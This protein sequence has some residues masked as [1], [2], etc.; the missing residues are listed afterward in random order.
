MFG[1]V[2]KN[3]LIIKSNFCAISINDYSSSAEAAPHLRDAFFLSSKIPIIIFPH[4]LLLS[5]N[6]TSSEEKMMTI[7]AS[8]AILALFVSC[9]SQAKKVSEEPAELAQQ[10]TGIRKIWVSISTIGDH[11]VLSREI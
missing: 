5:S 10:K 2:F 6:Q 11:R 4:F 7:I 8:L 1:F 3:L 9:D